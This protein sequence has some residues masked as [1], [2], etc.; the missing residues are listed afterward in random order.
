M[1]YRFSII[2]IT[3]SWLKNVDT[4]IPAGLKSLGYSFIQKC[5]SDGR[6]GG[7]IALLV[8]NHITIIPQPEICTSN[9]DFLFTKLKIKNNIIPIL[10]VYRPPNN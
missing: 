9:C 4:V 6:N 2:A 1:E 5:R 8:K 3:E 10:L 7:G